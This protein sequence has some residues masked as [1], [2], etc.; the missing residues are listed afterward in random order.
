MLPSKDPHR[1]QSFSHVTLAG[2]NKIILPGSSSPQSGTTG[3]WNYTLSPGAGLSR[4][5]GS[6][7]FFLTGAGSPIK[8]TAFTSF[9]N[10]PDPAHTRWVFDAELLYNAASQPCKL[11]LFEQVLDA[12]R[13]ATGDSGDSLYLPYWSPPYAL[14]FTVTCPG[15]VS[16][17]HIEIW[18][19]RISNATEATG[20]PPPVYLIV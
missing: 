16:H 19:M 12:N 18:R 13:P 7:G 2:F 8:A 9:P 10:L 15:T 11:A 17:A 5:P 20:Q 1:L 4:L 6:L 14:N 3:P